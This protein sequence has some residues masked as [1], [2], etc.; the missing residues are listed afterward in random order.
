MTVKIKA[1]VY[2]NKKWHD[3]NFIDLDNNTIYFTVKKG[4]KFTQYNTADAFPRTE[5]YD[6]KVS[7]IPIPKN[8]KHFKISFSKINNKR[9]P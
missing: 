3:V 2:D 6:T 4:F 7:N 5:Y 8:K 1:Q 9:K